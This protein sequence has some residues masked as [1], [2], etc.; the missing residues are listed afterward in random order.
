MLAEGFYTSPTCSCCIC[1]VTMIFLSMVFIISNSF[2]KNYFLDLKYKCMNLCLTCV[3][4]G[5]ILFTCVINKVWHY[6]CPDSLTHWDR[7]T[8]ICVSKLTIIG[9]ALARCQAIIWT[10]VGI[11]LI[12]PVG[13]N[14]SEISITVY[15]HSRKYIWKFRLQ[16]G[17]L[18]ISASMCQ[19]TRSSTAML[20]NPCVR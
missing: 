8:H 20:L 3:V 16:N 1:H 12:G 6:W 7:V 2:M 9:S 19:I 13:T 14:F 17:V 18:F 15:F 11:L 10:N 4:N 5:L